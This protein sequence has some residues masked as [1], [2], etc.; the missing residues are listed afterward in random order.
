[1]QMLAP[2][3]RHFEELKSCTGVRG[4]RIVDVGFGSGG[5]MKLLLD[6]AADAYGYEVQDRSKAA[7]VDS[8]IPGDRLE[9]GDGLSL[10]YETDAFDGACFIFSFH[11]VPARHQPELVSQV[12]RIVR[13]GG[14]LFVVEPLP[15]GPM[16]E[17]L[18]PIEDETA[19]RRAS[20]S[21]LASRK[22]PFDLESISHY[23]VHRTFASHLDFITFAVQADAERETRARDPEAVARIRAW[24]ERR[25][26]ASGEAEL[27]LAQ[28]CVAFWYTN[29]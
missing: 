11:H 20:Q 6:G 28:P 12:A 23:E 16:T 29:R 15:F 26:G 27:S 4:E 21:Y 9:V 8:G 3:Q 1:M 19:V 5:F 2:A 17:A 7:A 18:Q 25:L 10:P 22:M 24:F 13:P 14:W